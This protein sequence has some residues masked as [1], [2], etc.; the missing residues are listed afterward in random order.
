MHEGN[1]FERVGAKNSFF[2]GLGTGIGSIF[3]VGFF[4]LLAMQISGG[5]WFAAKPTADTAPVADTAPTEINITLSDKEWTRG[6]KNADVAIVTFSDTECPFCKRFHGVMQ[7]VM[8]EYKGKVKWIY[9]NFPLEQLH[10][11]APKEAEALECAND[12]GGT[13]VMWK[14]LDKVMELTQSNDGLPPA[15]L[16]EIAAMV[17]INRAKFETCLSSGKFTAAVQASIQA[18]VAAGGTGTPYSVIMKGDTKIPVP[19]AVPFSQ[20]KA[21]LD[22]LLK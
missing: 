11:Y 21:Y 2:L 14:Y 12:L 16:P 20:M 1:F 4:L 3:I 19:G 15:K 18:S 8:D 6:D 17:G 22:P 10:S 13:D 7:Q 5:T 9:R